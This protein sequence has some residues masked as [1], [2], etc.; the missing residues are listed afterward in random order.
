MHRGFFVVCFLG[1]FLL[2]CSAHR[3]RPCSVQLLK[4]WCS[5]EDLSQLSAHAFKQKKSEQVGD[6]LIKCQL[7]ER[8]V[9]CRNPLLFVSNGWNFCSKPDDFNAYLLRVD[10]TLSL[11]GLIQ[12]TDLNQ[13]SPHPPASVLSVASQDVSVS[14]IKSFMFLWELQE[15]FPALLKADK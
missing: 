1:F 15:K 2:V 7:V 11:M 5:G 4:W 9:F 14:L 10:I 6:S 8:K 3:L 12:T 13:S